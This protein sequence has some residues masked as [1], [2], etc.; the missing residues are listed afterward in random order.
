MLISLPTVAANVAPP[1]LEAFG[2]IPQT[3][4]V[5]LS[6]DGKLIAWAAYK[7]ADASV[8][9][10]DSSVRKIKRTLQLERTLKLRRL[11]WA[12][13][14]S[15]LVEMSITD[16]HARH[17]DQRFEFFRILA[18]DTGTGA[19][20]FLLMSGGERAYATG[21][22]LLSVQSSKPKTVVMSTYDYSASTRGRELGSHIERKRAD[23]GWSLG[24]YEVN[25]VSGSGTLIEAGNPYTTSFVVDKGGQVVARDDW[26]PEAKDFRVLVKQGGTWKEIYHAQDGTQLALQGLNAAGTALL[27]LSNQPRDSH[28]LLAL[29]LDGSPPEVAFED[30]QHE[31]NY[32]LHDRFTLQPIAV[33]VGGITPQ[34]HWLNP[35]DEARDASAKRAF[36]GRSVDLYSESQDRQRIIAYVYG[37]ENPPIYYLVDFAAHRAD[38][39][40]EEY[41]ALADAALGT[42]SNITYAARDGTQIPAYLTLP[43]GAKGAQHL[44]LVVLPHGGPESRDWPHFDW[45]S[46][47]LATR[48]YAVLQPQFR[49]STGFGDAFRLAGRHQWGGLMQDDVTD[50]VRDLIARGI[51]D[52]QRVCIVGASYGGYAALAGAAFTPDLYACAVSVNG[53]SNLSEMLGWE[54]DKH[55]KDSDTM[56]YWTESIGTK[57]DAAVVAKSPVKSVAQV[58]APILLIYSADDTVV[59]P[60]QSRE[61]AQALKER[62]A[63]HTLV[64]LDGDDHW[65]SRSDTRIQMLGKLEDFLGGSLRK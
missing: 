15:L 7:G 11:V 46:Q 3:D 61:M 48:G 45:W 14:E 19:T 27:A 52:P 43:P 20:K 25:T 6:P 21:A 23:Q 56:A 53:V 24:V 40:G 63:P 12:D 9:V 49:G 4:Y 37:P 18:L 10:F 2:T 36:A 13:N 8:V 16:P 32:V 65:L 33:L 38:I 30:A 41:P 17:E 55:G 50:G 35:A 42:V 34:Y 57:L 39:V 29:P 44:P 26:N 28:R 60:S 58:K 5:T 51:A 22:T 1:A 47:Y 59:P 62:G 31:V 54:S 64:Q